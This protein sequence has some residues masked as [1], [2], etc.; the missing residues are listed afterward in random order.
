MSLQGDL[1]DFTITEVL[2]L[3]GTQRKTGCLRLEWNAAR[4]RFHVLEGRLVATREPGMADDDPL[5][6]FLLKTRR[7]SNEQH[8]G[9]ETMQRESR[10][11]LEDLLVGGRY[12]DGETLGLIIER[13]ILDELM[14]VM[15]WTGGT[16]RFDMQARWP[17]PP[18]ARLSVE[19]ALIE[20]ARRVDEQRRF[21][22]LSRDPHRLLGVREMPGS[23]EELSEEECELF[24]LIDGRRTVAE[25]VDQAPLSE[26]ETF[27]ALQRMLEANWIESVGRRDPGLARGPL[28]S[29]RSAPIASGPAV[30]RRRVARELMVLALALASALGMAWGAR[31]LRAP[32]VDPTADDPFAAARVRDVRL[33]IDLYH[34][35]RGHYPEHLADLVTEDWMERGNTRLGG[36]VLSYR[37]ADDGKDYRLDLEPRR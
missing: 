3:L 35:E 37:V 12:L 23:E 25:I 27:E 32:A 5:L 9:I 17:N 14:R 31:A 36:R 30:S 10:R 20:V 6:N 15:T 2:Q 1:S 16:Y 22:E 19:G 34:R 4:A 26:Y 24:G 11:D 18:L 28:E 21:G 13:Q 7:L 8:R 33:A 29:T